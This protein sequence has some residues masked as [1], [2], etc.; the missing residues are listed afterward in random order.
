MITKKKTVR[1]F[2]GRKVKGG[3]LSLGATTKESPNVVEGE[4][5]EIPENERRAKSRAVIMYQRRMVKQR[6][7]EQKEAERKDK[8]LELK[9]RE[10]YSNA[11]ASARIAESKARRAH[12]LRHL[13]EGVAKGVVKSKRKTK[14]SRITM[15]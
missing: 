14:R 9:R 5:G 2:K 15:F 13:A 3:W 12:P 11:L 4:Y 7:A 1:Q 10:E 8:V 6:K